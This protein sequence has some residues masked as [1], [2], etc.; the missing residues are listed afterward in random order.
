MSEQWREGSNAFKI[1]KDIHWIFDSSLIF[2]NPGIKTSLLSTGTS[3]LNGKVCFLNVRGVTCV[4]VEA[5]SIFSLM[6]FELFE[7]ESKLVCL[8]FL[9]LILLLLSLKLWLILLSLK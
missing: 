9:I 4:T 3:Y 6:L 8:L 2:M 1:E 7:K 5:V